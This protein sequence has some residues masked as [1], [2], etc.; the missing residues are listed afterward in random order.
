[1]TAIRAA[2]AGVMAAESAAARAMLMILTRKSGRK[3]PFLSCTTICAVPMLSF[4][5]ALTF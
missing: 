2:S 5:P 1:M 4:F 3:L